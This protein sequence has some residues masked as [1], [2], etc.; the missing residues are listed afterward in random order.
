[1]VAPD[2]DHEWRSASP[3]VASVRAVVF[4]NILTSRSK[5]LYIGVTGNME[6]RL[7]SHRYPHDNTTFTSRYRVNR[8]VYLEEYSRVVDAIKS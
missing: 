3:E 4:V 1:M 8:L 2:V 6:R 7:N 5:V